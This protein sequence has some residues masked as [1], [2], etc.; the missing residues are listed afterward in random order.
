MADFGGNDG[1]A[2][3]NFYLVHKIKPLVIDCEPRRL[4]HASKAYG[5]STYEA[6][7]EDMKDLADKSIDW[8]FCSHTLEHTR[9]TAKAMREMARVIKR[10]CYFVMPLEDLKHA[11]KNHAHAICFTRVR[12]WEHLLESSGWSVKHSQKVGDYEAQ[13]YAEPT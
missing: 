10:G 6:F 5:L 2:A 8:G 13:M 7:L 4:E 11:R 1:Y 12:D 3:H 9:D